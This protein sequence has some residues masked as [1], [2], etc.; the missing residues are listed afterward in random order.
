MIKGL[1]HSVWLIL[2][3]GMVS[4]S[5]L[6]ALTERDIV[7]APQEKLPTLLEYLEKAGNFRLFLGAL[8][9]ADLIETLKTSS[10]Y[11]LLA[12]TDDAFR[13]VPESQMQ[14]LLAPSGKQKLAALLGLHILPEK[15][16]SLQLFTAGKAKT[17]QGQELPFWIMA[18]NY[19][20]DGSKLILPDV[21]CSNG[22]IDVI[23]R[24]LQPLP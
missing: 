11:T 8:A 22:V 17:L 1:R 6:S 3:L 15:Y 5:D 2:L 24:V 14:L 19:L 16:S 21:Q 10:N 7:G 23:D 13:R 9:K 12:P 4:A 20:I 18:G